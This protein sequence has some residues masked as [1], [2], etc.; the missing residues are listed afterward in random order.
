MNFV[1]F[2]NFNSLKFPS[3]GSFLVMA[4]PD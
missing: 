3:N 4:N 2:Q 1:E